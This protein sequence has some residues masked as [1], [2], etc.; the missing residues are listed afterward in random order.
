MTKPVNKINV[1]TLGCSKNLVDS[2]VL[3]KQ[4]YVGN[5]IVEHDSEKTDAQTVI[6]NT[7]GFIRDAK[8]ESIETILRFARAREKGEIR[9]LY[10]IGCLSERY[11]EELK[12]E[13]PDVDRY[14]GVNNI[15]QIVTSLGIE[16]RK[17][18][19]GERKLV[20]PGHYAYLKI[21]EGCDRKCAFCSIPLIRGKHKSR[22]IESLVNEAVLLVSQGV[23]ELILISQD[24]SYYGLDIYNR[25]RLGDLISRLSEVRGVE[26]IR[27]HYL[28]PANFPADILPVIRDKENICS[29]LDIPFQ[30]IADNV[31]KIMRRGISGKESY[32]LINMVRKE[33]PG[34]TL[35]TTLL[36]GHPG[37]S[38]KNFAELKEF[39]SDVR[40][41]RLGIFPYSHEEGTYSFK[42]YRDEIP[43]MI[44]MQRAEEIMTIQESI[45]NKLNKKKIGNEY[46]VIIDRK[47]EDYFVGRTE[48]DSPEVDQEVLIEPAPGLI[49][50]EFC[51]VIITGYDNFDLYGKSH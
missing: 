44:K 24:L 16:Y 15:E 42:N 49:T 23:K 36:T 31:L 12:N 34:I 48:S 47:E 45:S 17:E 46:K 40:F 4:L 19:L 14:F 33:V 39:V 25:Q 2:E 7:C 50:G 30:H 29:Y 5:F 21:A 13:I 8:E 6:I 35:R 27:L 43:E 38:E 11:K 37:E 1:I 51:N 32:D 10:V 18:L 20:T 28:F 26:W 3:L 9:N 41:D 22:T